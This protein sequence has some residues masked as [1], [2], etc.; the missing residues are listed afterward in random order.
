M[1][2]DKAADTA[3]LLLVC[4]QGITSSMPCMGGDKMQALTPLG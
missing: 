2:E 3:L 1:W 4:L